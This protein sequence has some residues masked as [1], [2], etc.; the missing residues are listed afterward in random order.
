M[1]ENLAW[2][3]RGRAAPRV[4]T[5]MWMGSSG[6]RANILNATFRE[7]GIGLA[8]GAPSRNPPA[9][10]YATAFGSKG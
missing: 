5:Q 3:L 7:V 6:H 1:G 4:I 8:I 2:G 10:T 9:A